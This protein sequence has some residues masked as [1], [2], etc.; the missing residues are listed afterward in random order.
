MLF[1]V[2]CERTVSFKLMM[3]VC[4]VAILS[5]ASLTSVRRD[6]T[7][8]I[9]DVMY[10][11]AALSTLSMLSVLSRQYRKYHLHLIAMLVCFCP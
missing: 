7:A 1:D 11:S 4:I 5:D 10:E 2:M 9:F 6:D 8:V 3:F